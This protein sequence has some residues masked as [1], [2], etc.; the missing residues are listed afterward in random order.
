MMMMRSVAII[1][2]AMALATPASAA[3][4][5]CRF[6]GRP[7]M[8]IDVT[9]QHERLTIGGQSAAMQVGNGFW[10]ADIDDQEYIFSF[11]ARGPDDP[12]IKATLV[13]GEFRGDAICVRQ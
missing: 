5:A 6:N 12:K 1:T 9:Y 3:T 2:I 8:L 13:S 4:Y 7:L 11:G 10:T